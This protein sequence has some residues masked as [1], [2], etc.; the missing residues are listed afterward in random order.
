LVN[1]ATFALSANVRGV[2][3][4]RPVHRTSKAPDDSNR[5]VPLDPF[6]LFVLNTATF[7]DIATPTHPDPKVYGT[8][9]ARAPP[10]PVTSSAVMN[11]SAVDGVWL[12]NSI[13]YDPFAAFSRL[14]F[15]IFGA[16]RSPYTPTLSSEYS[17][18][19]L[20]VSPDEFGPPA[21]ITFGSSGTIG[22]IHTLLSNPLRVCEAVI[23]VE[24]VLS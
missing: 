3:G 2:D 22:V 9:V 11:T 7:E 5:H 17:P 18:E 13:W 14:E 23:N 4:V 6:Q 20:N 8:V 24:F 10:A 19:I 16:H 15:A 1:E 21:T 12:S